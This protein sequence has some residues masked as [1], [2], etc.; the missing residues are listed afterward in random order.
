VKLY[1]TNLTLSPI[2][3]SFSFLL[4]WLIACLFICSPQDCCCCVVSL[5]ALRFSFLFFVFPFFFQPSFF[6]LFCFILKCCHHKFFPSSFFQRVKPDEWESGERGRERRKG[7]ERQ[8]RFVVSESEEEWWRRKRTECCAVRRTNH[9][10]FFFPFQIVDLGIQRRIQMSGGWWEGV[11]NQK[12]ETRDTSLRLEEN[13]T[14]NQWK[15]WS[16]ED[17]GFKPKN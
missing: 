15:R 16:D 11:A 8:I 7:E 12:R 17:E 14:I 2:F 3:F 13:E 4:I 5:F 1:H 6:I 9:F 10:L